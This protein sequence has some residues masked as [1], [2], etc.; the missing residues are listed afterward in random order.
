MKAPGQDLLALPDG[1]AVGADGNLAAAAEGVKYGALSFDS[2]PGWSVLEC[3]DGSANVV[4]V[5][6]FG[7]RGVSG[8]TSLERE[9]SLAGSRTELLDGEAV[10]DRLGAVEAI[11]PGGGEDERAAAK[12]S[13]PSNPQTCR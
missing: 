7:E 1:T 6:R 10:V 11:E 5:T 13:K 12:I 8:R 2:E 3:R 9:R 4:V